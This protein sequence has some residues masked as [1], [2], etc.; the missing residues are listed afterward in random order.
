MSKF[1]PD[2]IDRVRAAADM[3]EIV[4]AHTELRRQ[5]ARWTGLCPFHD[6]RS[7]SFGIHAEDKLYHC[8]GCQVGGDLFDFVIA[9]EN[10]DFP[11]AVE[12]LADRY[13]VEVTR[14]KEDPQAE[15]RRQAK[16]RLSELL[17]RAAGYYSAYFQDAPEASKARDYLAGRGLG[18][19]VLKLSLIHI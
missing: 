13:G 4:S 2:T 17:E 6:E 18:E 9:T 15:Q 8:F 12:M 10:V 5:G 1:T 11:G 19:E 3:V 7:P 14:E 16:N